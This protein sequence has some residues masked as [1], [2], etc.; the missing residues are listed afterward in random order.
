MLAGVDTELRHLVRVGGDGYEVPGHRLLVAAETV[1][2]PGPR[3]EGVGHGLQRGEGL[4]GD[5]E[6]GLGR[7]EVAD[8]LHQVAAVDVGNEAE[9]QVAVAVIAEGLVRHHRPE[10]GAADADVDHV[11]DG[12]A[13]VAKPLAAAH[14]AGEVGHPVEHGVDLGHDVLTVDDDRG[15]LRRAQGHVQHGAPLRDIDLIAAEHRVDPLAQAG[16]IGQSQQQPEGFVGDAVLRVVEIDP[17]RLGGQPFA[18]FWVVREQRAQGQVADFLM[19]RLEGL[20]GRAGGDGLD[21]WVHARTPCFALRAGCAFS[22]SGKPPGK[23]FALSPSRRWDGRFLRFPGCLGDARRL[24]G[25][26]CCPLSAI[27]YPAPLPPRPTC[28]ARRR[29]SA[30]RQS[31]R[32]TRPRAATRRPAGC[33]GPSPRS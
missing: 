28:R 6:Q 10:V 4:R 17:R 7:I 9:T 20:P 11:A 33:S 24:R 30:R 19:V 3:A 8:R 18:A 31:P 22:H 5:D 29:Q 12:P 14:A 15:A 13:R 25:R 26:R 21:H 2:R 27:T 1:Q 32:P 23:A 16:F